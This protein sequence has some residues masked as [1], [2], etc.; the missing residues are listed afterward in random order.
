LETRPIFEVLAT[1]F[2]TD[3]LYQFQLVQLTVA[4]NIGSLGFQ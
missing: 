2:L 1:A 4:L 3:D